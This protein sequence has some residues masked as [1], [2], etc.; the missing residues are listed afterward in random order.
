MA[1]GD[2]E[3]LPAEV[4]RLRLAGGLRPFKKK[5]LK[6][7]VKGT[8]LTRPP[9]RL[10]TRTPCCGVPPRTLWTCPRRPASPSRWACSRRPSSW[11]RCPARPPWAGACG[12]GKVGSREAGSRCGRHEGQGGH[13]AAGAAG[14]LAGRGWRRGVEFVK[15]RCDQENGR[16]APP[17][18]RRAALTALRS[19]RPG[20]PSFPSGRP[21][22]LPPAPAAPAVFMYGSKPTPAGLPSRRRAQRRY[23]PY[24]G[25]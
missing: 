14:C 5:S 18:A 23:R 7:S 6:K 12:T 10:R 22:L 17:A 25:R 24:E 19:G 11:P 3:T 16:S 20:P 8:I 15:R 2:P 1:V 21:F 13:K 4:T 9:R